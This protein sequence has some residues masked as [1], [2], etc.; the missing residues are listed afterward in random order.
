MKYNLFR[1]QIYV[2]AVVRLITKHNH[3]ILTG[4]IKNNKI[5]NRFKTAEWISISTTPSER[6]ITWIVWG[7]LLSYEFTTDDVFVPLLNIVVHFFLC[8][9]F[10]WYEC[11]PVAGKIYCFLAIIDLLLLL[12]LNWL[13][14]QE[15]QY[16][17]ARIHS[18]EVRRKCYWFTHTDVL[19]QQ[20]I[21]RNYT[22]RI[23][24]S[25]TMAWGKLAIKLPDTEGRF[26]KSFRRRVI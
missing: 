21:K 3:K 19:I 8:L 23:L 24:I 16:T 1:F 5:Y 4:F 7:F 13:I 6:E 10:R 2:R 18:S 12:L 9:D 22:L 14:P 11:G 25:N 26:V 17:K 20:L 15:V